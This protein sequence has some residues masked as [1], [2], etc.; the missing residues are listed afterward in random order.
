MDFFVGLDSKVASHRCV[1]IVCANFLIQMSKNLNW[2][3]ISCISNFPIP[4]SSVG[5][6]ESTTHNNEH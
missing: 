5:K 3:H 2:H 4:K 1:C 6:L